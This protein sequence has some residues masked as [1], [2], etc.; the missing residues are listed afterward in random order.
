MGVS[1]ISHS[2]RAFGIFYL[3]LAWGR[4]FSTPFLA[5]KGSKKVRTE[6]PQA[7]CQQILPL[8]RLLRS[9][10]FNRIPVIV[11]LRLWIGRVPYVTVRK[12]KFNKY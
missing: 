7:S 10:G 4:Q 5:L 1:T 2:R 3:L 8:L 9:F 12:A 11:L 6:M